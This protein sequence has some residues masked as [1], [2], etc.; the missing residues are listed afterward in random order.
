MRSSAVMFRG[1]K[2]TLKAYASNEVPAWSLWNGPKQLLFSF[3]GTDLIEG[4]AALKQ[5][6]E[7]LQEGGTTAALMLA[8]YDDLKDGEKI[9][10]TT[11]YDNSFNFCLWDDEQGEQSP[12]RYRGN[13]EIEDRMKAMEDILKKLSEE[14]EEDEGAE[15]IGGIQGILAG[16]LEVP[17]VKQALAGKLVQFID[18][19]TGMDKSKQIAGIPGEG[20]RIS[21]DL[22]QAIENE[23][24]SQAWNQFPVDQQLKVSKALRVLMA[25]DPKIGDHLLMLA[26][27]ARDNPKRYEMALTFL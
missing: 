17:E 23:K 10:N 14:P 21:I 5:A 2:S 4:E 15:K 24:F 25:S 7:L 13:K 1:V 6:L 11:P 20:N 22:D 8:V 19:I 3:N 12:Y 18:K 27:M 9:K 26:T 16:F